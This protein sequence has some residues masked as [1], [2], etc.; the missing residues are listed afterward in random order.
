MGKKAPKAPDYRGAAE[1]Q[2]AASRANTEYQTWANRP[3]MDTPW[4]SQTWSYD[5][6]PGGSSGEFDQTGY[7][8]AMA[9]W[10]TQPSGGKYDYFNGP[11]DENAGRPSS[12]FGRGPAP[13]RDQFTTAGSPSSGSSSGPG[14]WSSKITLAPEQQA[15]LDAQMR[16]GRG[17]SDAA[18]ELLGQATS[19]F[20]KPMDWGSLPASGELDTQDMGEWRQRGQSAIEELMAP[21]LSSRRSAIE[22]KLANQG[23]TMGSEA[24]KTGMRQLGDDETRAGLM[25]V[26]AGRNESESMFGQA[27]EGGRFQNL[28][29]QQALAEMLQ[30]RGQPLNELNA[31]LTGQQVNMPNMPNFQPAGRSETPNYMGAAQNSYSAALDSTNAS[32]AGMSGLMS[33]LFGLGSA[34]IQAGMF[35]DKRLKRDI[36]HVFTLENGI[37]IYK[38]RFIGNDRMEL[39]VLAQEVLEIMPEAVHMDESGFYKVDY[40]KVLA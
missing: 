4:G 33:G 8:K 10:E 36:S 2:A 1:E 20:Q 35:S 21:Q 24:W 40:N 39:G 34:G 6:G 38:Y 11:A 14:V 23:I 28:N 37:K 25:A 16:I 32:N 27:L 15:A 22:A 31:L 26:D 12:S 19:A 3:N 9:D 29:R 30:K 13:T 18:E 5:A 17:R 7:D